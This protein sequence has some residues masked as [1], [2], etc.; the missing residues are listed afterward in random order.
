M[1]INNL[2]PSA[3]S[4]TDMEFFW[5]EWKKQFKLELKC[6]QNVNSIISNLLS[7]DMLKVEE[8]KMITIKDPIKAVL[9]RRP[10]F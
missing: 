8:E 7:K 6:G 1:Q 4:L 2:A 3:V 5:T 10:S 9:V